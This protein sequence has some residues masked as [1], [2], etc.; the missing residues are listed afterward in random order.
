MWKDNKKNGLG[1]LSL[2][3]GDKFVGNWKDNLKHGLGSHTLSN[4][5]KFIKCEWQNDNLFR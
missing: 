1:T 2:A 5:D 4:G 3:N